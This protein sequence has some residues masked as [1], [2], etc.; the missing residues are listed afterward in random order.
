M[1]FL[2]TVDRGPGVSSFGVQ[3]QDSL[4]PG[5]RLIEMETSDFSGVASGDIF[6]NA[7]GGRHRFSLPLKEG[8][9]ER[10]MMVSLCSYIIERTKV[11]A[12]KRGPG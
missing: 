7:A 8:G 9:A 11:R 1:C 4:E 12:S 10:R 2:W 6:I 5:A 3:A